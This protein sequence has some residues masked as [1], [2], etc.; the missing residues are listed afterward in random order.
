MQERREHQRRLTYLGGQAAFGWR[1][2][3]LD[4][5]VRNLSQNGAQLVFSEHPLI[6]D[7]FDLMIAHT[8]DSRRARIAWRYQAKIGV[9]FAAY[10]DGRRSVEAARE[11]RALREQNVVLTRRIADLSD[12]AL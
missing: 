8:G 11:I 5:L 1:Y 12:P 2:C 9:R 10:D 3:A 6:P 4:C 7:E